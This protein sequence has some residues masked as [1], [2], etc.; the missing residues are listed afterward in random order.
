M[1]ML[2]I[3]GGIGPES[4]VDYYLSIIAKYRERVGD[5][6]S[7]ALIIDSLDV[8]RG[9]RM[10]DQNDLPDL[11]DYLAASLDRLVRAGAEIGL[12]A[13][14][15]PH[16]VFDELELRSPIPLISIVRA[17]CDA[18]VEAAV[19]RPA[20]LG[21]R[22]TMSG[23]FYPAAFENVGLSLV[24]PGASEQDVIHDIYVSELLNG[25]F[26]P[27]SRDRIARIVEAL[28]E[29]DSVDAVILAG[30]E[31]P[32]LLRETDFHLPVLDT[33]RIHVE[34]AVDAIL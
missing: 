22:F 14:N 5:D 19:R 15:T 24:T 17:T 18:A 9:L 21:T 8:R 4:T 16:I 2:G 13:A 33:T 25:K 30:T 12:M 31:L 1:R 26:L 28:I 6:S 20:L 10:L 11:I 34:A 23:R 32:L 3:I 7:P 27:E 29:R